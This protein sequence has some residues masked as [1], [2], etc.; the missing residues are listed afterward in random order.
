MHVPT[1]VRHAVLV[2]ATLAGGLA[3][4][5]ERER[6]LAAGQA[7]TT[8][9]PATTTMATAAATRTPL[10]VSKLGPQVGEQIPDFSLADQ[11]GKVWTRQSI[12]GP[13]GAMLVFIRS[14]DW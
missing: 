13:K 8:A 4:A 2:C 14:A 9:T 5:S 1:R 11:A 7:Q 12:M 6:L 10:D 3:V